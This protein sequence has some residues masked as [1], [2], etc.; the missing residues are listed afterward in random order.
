MFKD[1][2]GMGRGMQ[3]RQVWG[4]DH[5]RVFLLLS[6][7][8]FCF[9]LLLFIMYLSVLSQASIIWGMRTVLAYI[10]QLGKDEPGARGG[11]EARLGNDKDGTNSGGLVGIL[12]WRMGFFWR[13]GRFY[14]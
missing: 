4:L 2:I 11:D 9:L 12:E 13:I 6:S 5:G 3:G 8:Y 7:P 1:I 14:I 10:Y